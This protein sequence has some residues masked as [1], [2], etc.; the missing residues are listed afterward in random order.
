MELKNTDNDFSVIRYIIKIRRK[1][2]MY[3]YYV[4]I[5]HK[6]QSLIAHAHKTINDANA[7]PVS[8]ITSC[9]HCYT[10]RLGG[11]AGGGRGGGGGTLQT[12]L[13]L[14]TSGFRS[15]PVVCIEYNV[16]LHSHPALIHSQRL[17]FN[18]MADMSGW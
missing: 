12:I 13:A 2:C 8:F 9:S 10:A 15:W 16:N 18:L 1:V 11:K 3:I 14:R 6:K 17:A 5:T 7:F 4:K